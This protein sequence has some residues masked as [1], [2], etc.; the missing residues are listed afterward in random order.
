MKAR[1]LYERV[2]SV[3]ESYGKV[4]ERAS[5]IADDYVDIVGYSRGY[6]YNLIIDEARRSVLIT[7]NWAFRF[8]P[9]LLPPDKGGARSMH[10]NLESVAMS[11][12]YRF[13]SVGI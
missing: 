4:E 6:K 7:F 2:K 11:E 8:K 12:G 3:V 1:E 10:D 13:S 9:H 5:H